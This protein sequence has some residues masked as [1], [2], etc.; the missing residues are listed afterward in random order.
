MK[1]SY[2]VQ[3]EFDERSCWQELIAGERS[4][5]EL[6]YRHFAKD[7]FRFGY[8]L[9]SDPELVKDSIQEVFIDLWRYH[10]NLK[11]TD[12]VKFYLF[13][14]LSN[15][16]YKGNKEEVKRRKVNEEHALT[17]G[18]SLESIESKIIN[19]SREEQSREKLSKAMEA[20]PIRQKEVITYLFFESLSYEQ[21]SKLMNINLKSVYTLA[22]KAIAT[23]RKGLLLQ[24]FL[25]IY[26]DPYTF[27]IDF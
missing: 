6:I 5:L 23:L 22:W 26:F 15:Q 2:R 17:I 27:Y 13:K 19:L 14:C 10:S 25:W 18:S 16:I 3:T 8:S 7:L 11:S 9:V 12:N 1:N 24:F 4:S 21:T 20:L